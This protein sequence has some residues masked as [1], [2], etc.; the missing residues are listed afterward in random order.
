MILAVR[1]TKVR[2]RLYFE[3]GSNTLVRGDVIFVACLAKRQFPGQRTHALDATQL[4]K[5]SPYREIDVKL[6]KGSYYT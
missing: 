6:N 4:V 1:K 5:N 2:G 3:L